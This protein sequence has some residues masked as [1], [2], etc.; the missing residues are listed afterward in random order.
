MWQEDPSDFHPRGCQGEREGRLSYAE[1]PNKAWIDSLDWP[2]SYLPT[3]QCT[4]TLSRECS[5]LVTNFEG[6]WRQEMW[7]PS[8]PDLNV[9]DYAM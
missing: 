8:S 4:L 6:F 2:K 3:G 1:G 7:P 9:M 5:S